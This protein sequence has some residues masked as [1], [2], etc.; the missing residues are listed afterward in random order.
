MFTIKKSVFI[1][2]NIEAV[3][4]CGTDPNRWYKWYVGLHEPKNLIVMREIGAKIN[5]IY[6]FLKMDFLI[7]C[8]IVEN[9]EKGDCYVWKGKIKGAINSHQTWTYVPEEEGTKVI[10]DIEYEIPENVFE[11]V[12]DISTIEEIQDDSM[13]QTLNNLKN[14]CESK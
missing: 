12:D 10:V 9:S 1:N 3:Y 6:T 5:F 8:E 13:K 4:N 11:M 2:R 7:S 14:L